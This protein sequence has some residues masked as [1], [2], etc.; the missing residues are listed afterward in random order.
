MSSAAGISA[1]ASRCNRPTPG[2]ERT[3]ALAVAPDGLHPDD[4][5]Y[6]PKRLAFWDPAAAR[7]R[8]LAEETRPPAV[9]VF[10]PDGVLVTSSGT[11]IT[12]RDGD[13]GRVRGRTPTDKPV[14]AWSAGGASWLG[15]YADLG[16]LVDAA[17]G[18]VGSATWVLPP[19]RP[20]F[21]RPM[22]ELW[23]RVGRMD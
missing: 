9:L 19:R 11:G 16:K 8:A 20:W 15:G 21:S 22:V 4:R 13:T 6:P 5:G 10:G 14:L 3:V 12:F 1:P 23:S 18:K 2:Q 7:P 17:T